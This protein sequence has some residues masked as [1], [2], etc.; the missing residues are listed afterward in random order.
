MRRLTLRQ[1]R[2]FVS[3]ARHSSFAKAAEEM[4]LTAPAVSMQMRDLEEDLGISLFAK[5]GR[6]VTL[7]SAGEYFLVYARRVLTALREAEDMMAKL[8]GIETGTLTIGLVSTAKYIIPKLLAAFRKEH[9]GIQVI[10][11]VRNRDQLTV[12]LRDGEIDIAIMGRPPKDLDTRSES[13]SPHPHGFIAAPDHALVASSAIS[14]EQLEQHEIM[15]R[16]QGSGTRAVME[17]FFSEHR[18]RPLSTIEMSSNETIK[19]A[20]MAGLGISFVS[21][22]TIAL[23]LRHGVLRILPVQDT[24]VMRLWHVVNLTNRT[25]SLAAE[26]FRYFI[27]ERGNTLLE[28]MFSPLRNIEMPPK[29]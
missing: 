8:R 22:H 29:P 15:V 6:G 7:T 21:L 12:L 24:P 19:Q 9:P 10:I 5:K 3:A 25:L 11:Q 23:E 14:I 16:E 20:V 4:H 2:I 1:L 27:L 26:A 18:F 13:F 17:G 28:E